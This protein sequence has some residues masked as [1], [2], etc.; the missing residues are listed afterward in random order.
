MRRAQR[1]TKREQKLRAYQERKTYEDKLAAGM[2]TA[3]RALNHASSVALD[4]ETKPLRGHQHGP[5]LIDSMFEGNYSEIEYRTLA[6]TRMATGLGIHALLEASL[7]RPDESSQEKALRQALSELVLEEGQARCRHGAG[8]CR[9]TAKP[10][11]DVELRRARWYGYFAFS[12]LA[13]EQLRASRP[14]GGP[15]GE[16]GK[17]WDYIQSRTASALKNFL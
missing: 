4:F 16:S 10:R 15:A 8:P 14:A 17:A 9:I 6:Q 12:R 13:Q 11:E 5:V 1:R 3:L 7:K 2:E